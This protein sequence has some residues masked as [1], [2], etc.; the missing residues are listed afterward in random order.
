MSKSNKKKGK[1]LAGVVIVIGV[2]Y[3]GVS[4]YFSSV[5]V[6]FEPRPLEED[7]TN[8]KIESPAQFGLGGAQDFELESQGIL[9]KGWFYPSESAGKCAI[10][11]HHGFTGTRY[12]GMKY[13]PI[14]ARYGCDQLFFDAR[15]HGESG[16][17]FG[18][19]GFHEKQDLLNVIDWLKKERGLKDLNIGI[20]GES[21]GA[22]TSLMAAG[23]SGR[24]FAF[25]V[26]ESP[27]RDLPGI[28]VQR[29]EADYGPIIHLFIPMA[30]F[31]AEWRAD[32]DAD[33]TS[34]IAKAD[35][36]KTP[37]FLIHSRQDTYTAPENSEAVYKS[38][39]GLSDAEKGIY[40]TD[41]NAKHA[42]SIDTNREVFTNQVE[43]FL[44]KIDA[45]RRLTGTDTTP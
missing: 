44:D 2:M 11:Y 13:A 15:R 32:F 26:A 41:W 29:G 21:F 39:S 4:W 23:F 33:L 27:Y 22:A 25:I 38:L 8:L 31:F 3:F 6:D 20:M 43:T 24:E 34:V 7:R 18:T 19:F 45:G 9:L 12:G 5:L 36:I 40:F 14:F 35:Q 30:F 1:I 37:V 28:V 10:V 16:G 17:D 42:R